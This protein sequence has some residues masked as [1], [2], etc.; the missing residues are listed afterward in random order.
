MKIPDWKI[1]EKLKKSGW[2]F[3]VGVDEAGRG[4]LAGPVVASAVVLKNFEFSI[5]NFELNSNDKIL[6]KEKSSKRAMGKKDDLWNLVRDSKTLS[7]KQR[8]VAYKFVNKNFMVGVGI[9]DEK[10]IDR[11]NILEASFLAMK[12]AVTDLKK[13]IKNSEFQIEKK[14]EKIIILVDGN[15]KIPNF[16]IEQEA[17]IQGDKKVK[18]IAAA[19]IIAKVTRDSMMKKYD[20]EYPEYSFAEHK[21]Y[22]TKVHMEALQKFGPC[23]IHRQSFKPVKKVLFKN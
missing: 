5:L 4:P 1:E 20:K 2:D 19:S 6:S 3:V 22:G 14:E 12:M 17:I 16:S 15:K 23:K 11:I 8:D 10:T 9:C 7:E 18:S 13:K 21:G